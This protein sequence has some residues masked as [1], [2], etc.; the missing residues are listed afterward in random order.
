MND[1]P[2]MKVLVHHIF[3]EIASFLKLPESEFGVLDA[4]PGNAINA[5]K[6]S[7]S[8]TVYPGG[9]RENSKPFSE[10]YNIDFFDHYGYIQLALRARVPILP[11][12]GIGGG[13]TLFVLSSGDQIAKKTGLS[14][15]LKLHTWPIYWSLP[16][17]WHMGHF[18]F[19][20]LPLPSQITISVLPPFSIEKY[21]EN[22]AD[23]LEVLQQINEDIVQ[24]MQ[25]E[26]DRLS[27]GRIPVIG[28]I[29]D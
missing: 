8:V 26:M 1:K 3:H 9:D 27:E 6:S 25:E 19:L 15:F 22:D 5:L 16:F 20:S 4:C 18:P 11:I 13:E 29:E 28:K 12:V 24:L 2:P 17:G 14:K 10:R 23:N 7:N 21:S